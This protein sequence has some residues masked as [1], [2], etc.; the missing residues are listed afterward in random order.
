MATAFLKSGLLA[1]QMHCPAASSGTKSKAVD[2]GLPLSVVLAALTCFCVGHD[3]PRGSASLSVERVLL[4]ARAVRAGQNDVEAGGLALSKELCGE[5][6]KSWM[7]VRDLTAG[8]MRS[9][10]CPMSSHRMPRQVV[11]AGRTHANE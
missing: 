7:T 4:S 1:F 2:A 11:D 6:L 3:V 5:R 10:G 9:V 8:H